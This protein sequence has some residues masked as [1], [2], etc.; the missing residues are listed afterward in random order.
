MAQDDMRD[1]LD[2]L[3]RSKLYDFE[4]YSSS[5]SNGW[6]DMADRLPPQPAFPFYRQSFFRVAAA[7]ALL[8][9]VSGT[10][11]L[12]RQTV[13]PPLA[14][15]PS[16]PLPTGT[17]Q[18]SVPTGLCQK[19][20]Q[21]AIVQIPKTDGDEEERDGVKYV[22]ETGEETFFASVPEEDIVAEVGTMS[23][24]REVPEEEEVTVCR[25]ETETEGLPTIR[26]RKKV[27]HQWTLDASAGGIPTKKGTNETSIPYMAMNRP[28]LFPLLL[29]GNPSPANEQDDKL[30]HRLIRHAPPLSFGL[31]IS[32]QLSARLALVT[33]L[34][35]S[36][37]TSEWMN[38]TKRDGTVVREV[39][40]LHFV[41]IPLALQYTLMEGQ[42]W[43][44][45][46]SAGTMAEM[47]VLGYLHA[48]TERNNGVVSPETE[49][50]R[51]KEL[52]WSLS[53]ASGVSYLLFYPVSVYG[54]AGAACYFDNG[55]AVETVHKVHRFNALLRTGFRFGF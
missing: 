15:T 31:N 27:S 45:Y 43:R 37:L 35:Y 25:L 32:R 29:S 17:T 24:G 4:G 26:S 38:E 13:A 50:R 23:E 5:D 46:V 55:S 33:G 7:V 54:E 52:L 11:F 28:S 2:D 9:V 49:K 42:R 39:Q 34:T 47:N 51:M 1:Q 53:A 48:H 16:A 14:E 44:I 41:G 20:L 10:L 36:Y 21:T 3:F 22:V 12:F 30:S 6:V 40:Q 8:F 18:F 19:P